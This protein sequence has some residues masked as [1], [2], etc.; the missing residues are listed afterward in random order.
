MSANLFRNVMLILGVL[1]LT[2]VAM[3]AYGSYQ[4]LAQN[5]KE[6]TCLSE[7]G[8]RSTEL[9]WEAL[10]KQWIGAVAL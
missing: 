6:A 7:D 10:A 4:S 8:V 5:G 1:A 9:P 3:V 2:A